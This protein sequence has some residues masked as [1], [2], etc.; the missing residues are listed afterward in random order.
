MPKHVVVDG[1]NIATEGR[2][3]PSL[4]QLNEAVMA[5][6]AE[7]PEA[8]V[9]V[10]VDATFGH[11]IDKKEV[12]EFDEAVANN[13]LVAPPAGAIGR[14]DGFVLSIAKK[15]GAVILTNDSYQEFHAE[16][17]WLFDEG[18][19]IGG[20][21]VP[22]I[23]WVFVKRLPVRGPTS[24]K[25]TAEAKRKD[26]SADEPKPQRPAKSADAPSRRGAK[27]APKAS[28][29]ANQPMPV[30]T[31]PPP[32]AT[33]PPKAPEKNDLLPFLSFVEAHPVGSTVE[34]V[35]DHY[36]SHGAYVRLDGLMGYVPLRLMAD[37]APR[38]AREFMKIGETVSLVVERFIA[39][40]R[41]VDLAVPGMATV[42]APAPAKPT[43]GRRKKE[44]EPVPTDTAT[45]ETPAPEAPVEEAPT[46]PT[47]KAAA[48][49]AAA[50][51]TD[52]AQQETKP[53]APK[54]TA[55]KPAA[56]KKTA[57]KKATPKKAEPKKAEPKKE[58][59]TE[60]PAAKKPARPRK[61]AAAAEPTVVVEPSNEAVPAR[62]RGRAK[63]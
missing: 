4:R 26:R 28:V 23:G 34:A 31:A 62:R 38:S 58:M 27:S 5:F 20:K 47:R 41:S 45:P 10:V 55:P 60:P 61:S 50:A 16:Y 21:P 39:D 29:E 63:A 57:P 43:R 32:N 18:R 40:K 48:K 33:L 12:A 35:V 42:A 6:M 15:V 14:G 13:E 2:D 22:H 52:V 1:S 36:S 8:L 3:H 25:V 7:Y 30:P 17:P 44:A 19:L 59:G 11:R 24:R 53:T 49:K 46:K 56:A 54:P 37:P 9:T 51:P